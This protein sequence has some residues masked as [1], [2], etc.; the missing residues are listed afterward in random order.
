MVMSFGKS[1]KNGA[2]SGFRAS[3]S[4]PKLRLGVSHRRPSDAE[5]APGKFDD[6]QRYAALNGTQKN[7]RKKKRR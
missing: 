6:S 7:R 3:S 5:A 1:R 4:R 2:T